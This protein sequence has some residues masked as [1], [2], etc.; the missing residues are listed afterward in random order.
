MYSMPIHAVPKPGSQKLRLVVNHSMGEHSLNSMIPRHLI[1]G[2][3]LDTL[4]NL[5]DHLLALRGVHRPSADLVIWKSDVSQAYRRLP[6]HPLWQLK[7]I[8][9]IDGERHIDRCNNFGNRGACWIWTSFMGLVAWISNRTKATPSFVYIDDNFS[10]MLA[11]VTT[12]Y[13]PYGQLFPAD[14]TALLE[15]WDVLRLSHEPAKQVFG[16]V[17]EVIGFEV[18]ANAMTFTMAQSKQTELLAGLQEFTALSSSK[19]LPRHALRRFQQIAGWVN[20]ALNVHPLLKPA[21]SH[22]YDK[23]GSKTQLNA[24]VYVNHGIACDLDWFCGHVRNSTGVHILESMDW[25]VHDADVEAFCD[26]S[27]GGLGI[28]F[29]AIGLGY[30]SAP[31]T[32]A[33]PA[34]VIFYL[35][36]LCVCWCLHRVAD[37][38]RRN[39]SVCVRRIAIWTDNE[40][41][42]HI[43]SSLC[44]KPGYNEILKSSVDILLLNNFQL[45]VLLIPG[46]KNIVADTLSRWR[47]DIAIAGHSAKHP[48][49]TLLIDPDLSPPDVPVYR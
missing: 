8:I 10:A 34:G 7:Q 21:L 14:Q 29:P 46:K 4:K 37:L 16:R 5:G 13:K 2:S 1:A 12:L 11:N 22:V 28:Y 39:G 40:N 38:V 49:S 30:Q 26:A 24:L 43:F 15:L 23:I 9:T 48:G 6:M 17:L 35:E 31:P 25:D 36:A 19:R 42:F 33:P 18:N 27:L 32:V 45:R 44:A 41:T 20:W 3:R 47:N